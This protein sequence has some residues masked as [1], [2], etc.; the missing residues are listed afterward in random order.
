M[1]AFRF[2]KIKM[3]IF[4][5]LILS[6]FC[7][8]S[9]EDMH[10][11][12]ISAE[13]Q[14]NTILDNTTNIYIRRYRIIVAGTNRW[15]MRYYLDNS[16]DYRDTACDGTNIYEILW[17]VLME[18]NPS[19][20][21]GAAKI[22]PFC[23]PT[24]SYQA[25][26]ALIWFA[27]ASGEYLKTNIS[28]PALWLQPFLDPEAHIY[29]MEVKLS[30]NPPYLPES[31]IWIVSSNKI[32]NLNN[33]FKKWPVN[34]K[35]K[36]EERKKWLSPNHILPEPIG[37][38][39]AKYKVLSFTNVNG[40]Y[41]PLEFVFEKYEYISTNEIKP[42]VS[43]LKEIINGLTRNIDIITN[44]SIYPELP[45]NKRVIIFD[46]RYKDKEGNMLSISYYATNSWTNYDK[47]AVQAKFI[48]G[49]KSKEREKV[50]GC[51]ILFTSGLIILVGTFLL[52]QKKIKTK[53][54]EEIN[55]Q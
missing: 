42:K 26:Q 11:F 5:Y 48:K 6:V 33:E 35:E 18:N 46:S 29:D 49:L 15:L 8:N 39:S 28:I 38:I 40:F 43:N 54:Q 9:E 50:K 41:F 23:I 1:N 4:I 44:Y 21:G 19:G 45:K 10:A 24:I 55:K 30:N 32:R 27:Y 14:H 16:N 47:E 34:S 3:L 52:I 51:I 37:F 7:A 13:L 25:F 22:S 53:K 20:E 12:A 31:A 17:T 2:I 36:L